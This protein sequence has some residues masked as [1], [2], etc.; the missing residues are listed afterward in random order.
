MWHRNAD[1][2]FHDGLHGAKPAHGSAA[3]PIG[4]NDPALH[5]PRDSL[6]TPDAHRNASFEAATLL[7][8]DAKKETGGRSKSPPALVLRGR[9]LIMCRTPR[10]VPI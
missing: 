8:A 2:A 3:A 4:D 10:S 1:K 5:L 9:N 7:R 6:D